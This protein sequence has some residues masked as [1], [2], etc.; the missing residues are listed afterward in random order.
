MVGWQI[1]QEHPYRLHVK[2]GATEPVQLNFKVRGLWILIDVDFFK[3]LVQ[4]V[5]HPWFLWKTFAEQDV[6]VAVENS[7]LRLDGWI[8]LFFLPWEVYAF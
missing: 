8:V 3:F 6:E 1:A 2:R 5:I 4:K 7:S